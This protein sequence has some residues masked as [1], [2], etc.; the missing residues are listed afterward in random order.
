[1]RRADILERQTN[2]LN[3]K[4]RSDWAKLR[5]NSFGSFNGSDKPSKPHYKWSWK[6][7]K[8]VRL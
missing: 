2:E 3:E 5:A 8:A 4:I 1:M 6:L 7:N